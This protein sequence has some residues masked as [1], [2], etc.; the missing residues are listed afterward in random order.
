MSVNKSNL[1][2][3]SFIV[4]SRS[5]CINQVTH[6][7]KNICMSFN[8]HTDLFHTNLI[9][10]LKNLPTLWIIFTIISK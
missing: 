3:Y 10:V 8:F 4:S 2:L 5:K 1:K 6:C 9:F 7:R